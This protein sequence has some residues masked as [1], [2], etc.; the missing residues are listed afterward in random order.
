MALYP[1]GIKSGKRCS[2][3][4][5]WNAPGLLYLIFNDHKSVKNRRQSHEESREESRAEP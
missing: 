3:C 4:R 5:Q 1:E 2:E